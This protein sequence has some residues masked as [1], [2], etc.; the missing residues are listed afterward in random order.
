MALQESTASRTMSDVYKLPEILIPLGAADDTWSSTSIVN[1][2]EGR[3]SHTAIWTGSEMIIW[4]GFNF[5]NGYLMYGRPIQSQY[6]QLD[7]Y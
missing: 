3:E 6:R 7:D 2:P 4:G 5:D 1:A